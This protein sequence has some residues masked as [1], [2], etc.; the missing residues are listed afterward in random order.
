MDIGYGREFVPPRSINIDEL[1]LRQWQSSGIPE[2]L[3]KLIE[4]QIQNPDALTISEK[5]KLK[6]D[7]TKWEQRNKVLDTSGQAN[8]IKADHALR[9]SLYEAYDGQGEVKDTESFSRLKQEYRSRYSGDQQEGMQAMFEWVPFLKLSAGIK[10]TENLNGEQRKQLFVELTQYQYLLTHFI[11]NNIENREFIKNFWAV[12]ERLAENTNF[13]SRFEIIKK[14]I[15]TQ[16]ATYKIFE[17]LHKHPHLSH[18]E[19]DAFEAIDLLTETGDAIQIKSTQTEKPEFIEIDTQVAVGG[20]EVEDKR[21]KTVANISSHYQYKVQLAGE[22]MESY[23]NRMNQGGARRVKAFMLV[24]PMNMV[25]QI[26]GKPNTELVKFVENNLISIGLT[27][28]VGW[29]GEVSKL[30]KAA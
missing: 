2:N 7:Q 26:T 17:Y 25:D 11:K 9:N 23:I 21:K 6:E 10:K 24:V 13:S 28:A 19:Q 14:G 30:A 12:L 4:K 1:K 20:V 29:Q 8:D 22:K 27:G 15:L 3:Q 5:K 16:V 18:P